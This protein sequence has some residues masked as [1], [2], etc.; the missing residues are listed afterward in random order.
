MHRLIEDNLEE[1]LAGE[2]RGRRLEELRQHLEACAGCREQV[3][4]FEAGSQ[5]LRSLRPGDVVDPQPGF[6]GRVRG[7][8][9]TQINSSVWAVF[10]EP[11]FAR[12]LVYSSLALVVLLTA[13]ALTTGPNE[14][15]GATPEMYIA[16][17]EFP[18]TLGH[19]QLL[20]RD[21]VL[22]TLASYGEGGGEEEEHPFPVSSE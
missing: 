4:L 20:D 6:Y 19:D 18:P 8:V 5:L 7:R 13:A 1:Y 14:Y 16:E 9:E 3:T 17:Q 12:R 15:E 11:M 10:F 22:T 21:I 2:V